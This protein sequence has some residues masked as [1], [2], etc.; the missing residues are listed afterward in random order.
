MHS[1]GLGATTE[2]QLWL[3]WLSIGLVS[4]DSSR[5]YHTAAPAKDTP[6]VPSSLT[7]FYSFFPSR[8]SIIHQRTFPPHL[9]Q[10]THYLL[11]NFL[12]LATYAVLTILIERITIR[13]LN[14]PTHPLTGKPVPKLHLDC[15]KAIALAPA[16][17]PS[18]ERGSWQPVVAGIIGGPGLAL[19]LWWSG[20]EEEAGWLARR[21]WRETSA[22]RSVK[23]Q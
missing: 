21:A 20:G 4:T 8:S 18:L 13:T 5:E 3:P 1:R 2:R 14:S 17:N 19:A 9:T 23:A 11:A 7:P 12:L 22:V 10:Q 6:I 16:G 15:Q